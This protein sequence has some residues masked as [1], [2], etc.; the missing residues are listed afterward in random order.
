M[1]RFGQDRS[2][3]S[4][5]RVDYEVARVP[6][7]LTTAVMWYMEQK[8]VGKDVLAKRLGVAPGRVSQI[9]SGDENL[10]VCS[11][12]AVCAALDARLEAKLVDDGRGD[13]SDGGHGWPAL[14]PVW[15]PSNLTPTTFSYS[16]RMSAWGPPRA[17]FFE[18]GR[19]AGR[20]LRWLG[21]VGLGY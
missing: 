14:G 2:K 19:W 7:E 1:P 15:A 20:C 21:H 18:C 3:I 5:D 8:G 4:R 11:L 17:A 16:R 12:A 6:R 10:T 13:R 9:L